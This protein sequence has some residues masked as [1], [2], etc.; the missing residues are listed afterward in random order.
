MNTTSMGP[1]ERVSTAR[2]PI[3]AVTSPAAHVTLFT[4]FELS[5][6]R[7]ERGGRFRSGNGL[8]ICAVKNTLPVG[9]V[10]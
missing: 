9:Y 10:K 1:P 3:P 6:R 7:K 8:S 4:D 5:G 2:S